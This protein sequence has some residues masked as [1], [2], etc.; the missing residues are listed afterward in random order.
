MALLA[1]LLWLAGFRAVFRTAPPV[2]PRRVAEPP[3]VAWRPPNVEGA[4]HADG[5]LMGSP[6]VFALPSPFGFT[7]AM[8]GRRP[9]LS[10]PMQP[11]RG[12]PAYLR[13]RQDVGVAVGGGMGALRLPQPDSKPLQPSF[14]GVFRARAPEPDPPQ[15]A[16]S[17]GWES[18]LF[19][20]IDLNFDRWAAEPW[21]ARMELRFD[22]AGVPVSALVT[23]PSGLGEVDRRLSR[24]ARGWRL[25]DAQ[26]ARGGTVT[27]SSPARSAGA[28]SGRAAAPPRAEAG[29]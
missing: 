12:A 17:E 4:P 9:R 18:R 23:Q 16:F 6:S 29:P 24:S 21:T 14:E 2:V 5:A 25:L 28:P 7:G 22:G 1:A 27:W 11:T 3:L 15:M 10:P 8:R 26:A 20:G 13:W 19:S